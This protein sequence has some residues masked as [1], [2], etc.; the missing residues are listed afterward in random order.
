MPTGTAIQQYTTS[1]RSTGTAVLRKILETIVILVVPTIEIG[2]FT[3]NNGGGGAGKANM[4][5]YAPGPH[6]HPSKPQAKGQPAA[7]GP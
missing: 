1:A 6:G 3:G 2:N 5:A 7:T 4:S